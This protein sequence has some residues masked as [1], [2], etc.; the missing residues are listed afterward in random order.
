[1][2]TRREVIEYYFDRVGVRPA[3]M[4]FYE[5][6]G[7]FRLSVIAQ[8]VYYRYHRGETRNPAFKHFW[9]GVAYLH[10]RCFRIIRSSRGRIAGA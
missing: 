8:Q 4:A 9:L 7:L 1:M 2:L 6:Y 3:D 10:Y 5:V